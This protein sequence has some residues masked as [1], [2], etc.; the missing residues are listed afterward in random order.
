MARIRGSYGVAVTIALLGL[1]PNVALQTAFLPVATLVSGDLGAGATGVQVAEGLASAAYAV[2]AVSAAQLAQAHGQRR[3]FLT[4]QAVFVVGSV[5]T[6]LAPGLGLFAA[7]R[8]LQGLSAGAMLIS[9]LPPLIARFP[10]S[11]LPATAAV[12]NV[13]IFGA[14]TVGPIVGGWA[15]EAGSWRSLFV[16]S[17]VVGALGWVVALVGYAELEPADPDQRLDAPLLVLTVAATVA[18]FVGASLLT[19]HGIGEP[20]V[21]LPL[22]G[23]IAALLVLLVVEDRRDDALIPVRDLATQVPVTGILVASVGGAVFVAAVE[24]LQQTLTSA[25]ETAGAIA[26]LCWPMPVG[27]VLGAVAFAALLR[28]RLVPVLVDVGLALLLVATVL[29]AAGGAAP[30]H[31]LVL[32]VGLLLGAGAGATV[33][34]GLFLAGWALPSSSLGKAFALVQLVRS[35]VTYAVAPVLLY[36]AI[37]SGLTPA[38]VA[39]AILAGVGLVAALALPAFSGARLWK[40]DLE[41]WLDGG[42]ALPSPRTGVHLRP[43][44]EDEDARPL[45]PGPLRRERGRHR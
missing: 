12:V 10:A 44:V 13:G 34:P 5:A 9:S 24:L 37:S 26:A 36:V 30:E 41:G 39:T 40:P 43:G 14:S 7:G 15:A 33:S 45:V 38:L 21:W 20:A 22:A 17:A 1:V 8:V 19:G 3:L 25:G 35:T 2:G 29:Q 27:V 23:G 31:G 16:A 11:R 42:R 4:Y 28:T 6:L 32:V 18:T